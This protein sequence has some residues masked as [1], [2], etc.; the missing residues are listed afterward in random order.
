MGE[1]ILYNVILAVKK[2]DWKPMGK[3]IIKTV[4]NEYG[5]VVT[6]S[7]YLIMDPIVAQ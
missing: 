6:V 4:K 3:R 1:C 7:I 2:Y 5:K